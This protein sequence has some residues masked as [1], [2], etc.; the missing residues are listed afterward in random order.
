[1][2]ASLC[3]KTGRRK[4]FTNFELM[5]SQMMILIRVFNDIYMGPGNKI[6]QSQAIEIVN[7]S[8]VL[9]KEDKSMLQEEA[10]LQAFWKLFDRMSKYE[11]EIRR[12]TYARCAVKMVRPPVVV[13]L[14]R[15][16]PK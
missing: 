4:C 12:G 10:I 3:N 2:K 1:M 16:F 9:L 5:R 15:V 8:V 14:S 7:H 11:L 13:P 6:S